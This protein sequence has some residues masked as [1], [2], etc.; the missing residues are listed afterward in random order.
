MRNDMKKKWG[1]GFWKEFLSRDNSV[2]STMAVIALVISAPIIVLS[3]VALIYD[4]FYLGH[5]L[6]DPSVKLLIALI[7]ASTG[8]L[9]VSQFSKRTYTEMMG[10][11]PPEA[12]SRPPGPRGPKPEGGD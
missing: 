8:G 11:I 10:T 12:S 6:K 2:V 4:I 5:G 1:R 9:T 3:C 7:T